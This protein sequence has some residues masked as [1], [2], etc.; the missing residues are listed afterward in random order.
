MFFGFNKCLS[1]KSRTK[2]WHHPSLL[3]PT[4]VFFLNL[5]NLILIPSTNEGFICKNWDMCNWTYIVFP[6][7]I[8]SVHFDFDGYTVFVNEPFKRFL[9]FI[10]IVKGKKINDNWI[11]IIIWIKPHLGTQF[12][13]PTNYLL[14]SLFSQK[15]MPLLPL[16]C[17]LMHFIKNLVCNIWMLHEWIADKNIY[18]SYHTYWILMDNIV[19]TLSSDTNKPCSFYLWTKDVD[20]YVYLHKNWQNRGRLV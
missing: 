6:V 11:M 7:C 20:E 2:K 16:Y 10:K 19:F 15:L 13:V 4:K 17:N 12:W 8:A 9:F 1:L 18:F 14:C 3:L 5:D